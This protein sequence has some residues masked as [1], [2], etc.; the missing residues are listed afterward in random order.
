VKTKKLGISARFGSKYG[1]SVRDRFR[2]VQRIHKGEH[3]CPNCKKPGLKRK[4]SGI[5]EC[6]KCKH[7]VAGKAYK[8]S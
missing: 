2:D 6:S 1:K 3:E 4:A 8:P 5:W 7:K